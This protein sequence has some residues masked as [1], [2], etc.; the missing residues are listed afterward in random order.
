MQ[1]QSPDEIRNDREGEDGSRPTSAPMDTFRRQT[2]RPTRM[3]P[4]SMYR[5][6][7]PCR[8]PASD[9]AEDTAGG[10][11]KRE[12]V[13]SF[14]PLNG[15]GS[16]AGP[17]LQAPSTGD[18]SEAKAEDMNS[19]ESGQ[20]PKGKAEEATGT[21]ES[22]G[23]STV[24]AVYSKTTVQ[25]SSTGIGVPEHRAGGSV[26]PLQACTSAPSTGAMFHGAANG[27]APTIHSSARPGSAKENARGQANVRPSSSPALTPRKAHA[28]DTLQR[29]RQGFLA[30]TSG[31]TLL[32]IMPPRN[33]KQIHRPQCSTKNLAATWC[34]FCSQAVED[35]RW[36]HVWPA[37]MSESL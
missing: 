19:P 30:L 35:R 12:W 20:P 10:R 23:K 37:L 8:Q 16:G 33:F 27:S 3:R 13:A 31:Q 32:P 24:Q 9:E 17:P 36:L 14:S 1:Q 28:L 25:P 5:S 6:E 22:P 21:D 7:S 11:R 15:H 4:P 34:Q 29:P 18:R 26:Q 2:P